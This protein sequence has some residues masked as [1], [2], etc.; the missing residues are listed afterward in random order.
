[1]LRSSR[2]ADILLPVVFVAFAV[3]AGC[4]GT[5]SAAGTTP[6]AWSAAAPSPA[7]AHTLDCGTVSLN[8]PTAPHDPGAASAESC[9]LDAYQACRYASLT[10]V[11]QTM[12]SRTTTVFSVGSSVGC[13]VMASN[14][15]QFPPAAPRNSAFTCAAMSRRDGGLLFSDCGNTG[16]IVVP[17]PAALVD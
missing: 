9:L 13:G 16:D 3:A 1:M 17:G 14:T 4:G 10:V 12:D 7:A 8:G 6:A 11:S 5:D 2:H 15:T